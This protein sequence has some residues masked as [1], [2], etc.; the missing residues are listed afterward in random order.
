MKDLKVVANNIRNDVID[1]I[2]NA[3]SGHLGGSLS[4]VDILTVLY[5]SEMNLNLDEKGFRIDKLVLSKGHSA[6]ALYAT[7]ASVNLLD[8][9]LLNTLRK[10]DSILEGHPSIKI[11]GIDV[12]S[13]SLRTRFI[14]C[15]WNGTS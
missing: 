6:P 9:N 15:K 10:A 14:Y 13:G 2:Y 3:G 5:H 7:L 12:S 8:K 1:M 4:V 11:P